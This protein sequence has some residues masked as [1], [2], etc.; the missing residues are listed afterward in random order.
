MEG[1]AVKFH[2]YIIDKGNRNI[3]WVHIDFQQKHWSLDFFRDAEDERQCYEKM[4][5][6]IFVDDG[7]IAATGD[8][9]ALCR[10]CPAYREMVELQKLDDAE[11]N[12]EATE[13]A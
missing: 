2:S 3:S 10:E 12:G 11:S 4:D 6:I 1:S 9:D 13:N 8:H 5:K 7:K